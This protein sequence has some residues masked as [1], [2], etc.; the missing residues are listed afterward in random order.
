METRLVCH[1]LL[2]D[3]KLYI[4]L[5]QA[6][7]ERAAKVRAAGCSCGGVLHS[8][9]YRRKPRGVPI[10]FQQVDHK[11]WSFCCDRSGCRSRHTPQSVFYL[12]RRVYVGAVMLLGTAMRCAVSGR[13]LR[14]LCQVLG[15]PRATLDRWR[16]W[17]NCAFP[18]TLFWQDMRGEFMPPVS[19]PLPAELLARFTATDPAVQLAQALRFVA[20]LS[21]LTEGR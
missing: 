10:E 5:S 7:E 16:A 20:P 19:A 18:A 17:W 2:Q 14:E 6:D 8:A 4:L 3:P 21:T 13:A 15:V 1:I 12:G 9:R 11:R